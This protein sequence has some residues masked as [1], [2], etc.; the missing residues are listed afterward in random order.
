M[1]EKNFV[2]NLTY[3]NRYKN[4][5]QKKKKKKNKPSQ[6]HWINSIN[7]KHLL[8]TNKI[9]KKKEE[10]KKCKKYEAQRYGE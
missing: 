7:I 10:K 9:K 1:K 2:Q 8:L 6:L 4:V 5:S 3:H